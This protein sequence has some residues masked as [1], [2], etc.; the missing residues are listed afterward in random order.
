M[1]FGVICLPEKNMQV[2]VCGETFSL[3]SSNDEGYVR[4]LAEYVDTRLNEIIR[5]RGGSYMSMPLKTALLTLNLADDLFKEKRKGLP[6]PK[7]GAAGKDENFAFSE[8]IA[9]LNALL[10]AEKKLTGKLTEQNRRLA[11][12]IEALKADLSDALRENTKLRR[13]LEEFMNEFGG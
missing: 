10:S 2:T 6:G 4:E 9:G 7:A 12:S 11:S 8:K 3:A 13:E 1:S 5:A